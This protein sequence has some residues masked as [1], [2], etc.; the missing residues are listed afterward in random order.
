MRPMAPDSFDAHYRAGVCAEQLASPHV[1]AVMTAAFGFGQIVGPVFAGM[2][3]DATG[4]F[5]VPSLTA[6][7]A[8]LAGATLAIARSE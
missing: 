1:T 4:T 8:L 2:V 3:Y 7:G 6:A 5:V